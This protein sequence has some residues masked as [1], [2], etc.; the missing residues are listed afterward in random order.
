MKKLISILMS[1][2]MLAAVLVGCGSDDTV[3]KQD[4]QDTVLTGTVATDGSTSM[5]KVI[6][7]LKEAYT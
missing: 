5:E 4:T 3:S 2:C 6:E 1:V 7:Y